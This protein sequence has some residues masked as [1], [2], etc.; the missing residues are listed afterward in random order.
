MSLVWAV[1]RNNVMFISALICCSFGCLMHCYSNFTRECVKL[2]RPWGNTKRN[3][4]ILPSLGQVLWNVKWFWHSPRERLKETTNLA[5]M[6]EWWRLHMYTL[7][8]R[9][10]SGRYWSLKTNQLHKQRSSRLRL[11]SHCRRI[12]SKSHS[13][14]SVQMWVRLV[15]ITLIKTLYGCYR[16]QRVTCHTQSPSVCVWSCS[17]QN[18]S[19]TC[20]NCDG[21]D[22]KRANWI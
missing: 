21:S 13:L 14:S 8:Q 7:I 4:N 16:N 15:P 9:G 22:D 18:T 3:V 6:T 1:S 5:Q 11:Q 12:W 10:K 2:M 17:H 19:V 20:V